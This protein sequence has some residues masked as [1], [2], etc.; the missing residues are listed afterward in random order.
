V[1][2]SGHYISVGSLFIPFWFFTGDLLTELYG[3]NFTRRIIVIALIC[4]FIFAFICFATTFIPADQSTISN[5]Y[6]LV[7]G[8]MPRLAISSLLALV[9]GALINS[10]LLDYWKNLVKGRYFVLRSISTTVIG[11]VIFSFIA[12]YSQFFGKLAFKYIVEMIIASVSIKIVMNGIIVYPVSIIASFLKYRENQ[13]D[14]L[15]NQM[16]ELT[17]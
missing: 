11:E 14:V 17:K 2:L 3:F 15:P 10:Y 12:I 9:S 13:H 1:F 4:Q 6:N 7:F 8:R 5:A 16:Q